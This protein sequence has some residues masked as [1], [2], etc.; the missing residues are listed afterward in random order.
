MLCLGLLATTGCKR[1][2]APPP[3]P[4][5]T[6][7]PV[8]PPG[9]IVFIQR[10]HLARLDLE[11]SQIT[12]LT[13]GKSTEWF[14]SCSPAGDQVIYWSNAEGGYNLWKINLD[15]SNRVQI[16]FE[17]DNGL[18][19]GDQNLLVNAAASWSA[20]GK[21]IYYVIGGDLW[22]MDSDGFN[23]ETVLLGHKA[24]CPFV[25]A[26]GKI[27][28]FISDIDDAVRNLWALTLS[29]KT[30][31]KLTEYTDWNVGSPSMSSDGKKIIFNLYRANT[32]QVYTV[33]PD[34]SDALNLTT[35]NR[36]LCPRFAMKDRKIVYCAYGIGEDVA[37][38]MFIMNNNGTEIKPLTTE[39]G[40]SPSW[41]PAR[42]LSIAPVS[43]PVTS[44]TPA[45][46]LPTPVGSSSNASK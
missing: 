11:S 26:D 3:P 31:K 9:S 27:L 40:S 6:P 43:S 34:G 22:V 16:T 32:S 13:S 15:G 1:K 25:S 19:T 2:E 30:A 45:P 4:A 28:Y 33:S 18:Q 36:S 44:T 12:P 29:D 17:Q 23:P 10:G 38:N 37:L 35:N 41:A 24:L 14:P 39:G 20:D 46:S 21:R 7:I 5:P 8:I 42:I